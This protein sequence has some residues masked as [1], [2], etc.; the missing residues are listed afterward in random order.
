MCR[1]FILSFIA[2]LFGSVALAA[3]VDECYENDLPGCKDLFKNKHVNVYKL[4]E[5]AAIRASKSSKD[6]QLYVDLPKLQESTVQAIYPIMLVESLKFGFE[7]KHGAQYNPDTG[8]LTFCVNS[9]CGSK[10]SSERIP[11]PVPTPEPVRQD[12]AEEPPKP[13]QV[14]DNEAEVIEL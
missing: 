14:D 1:F 3:V 7:I 13:E 12:T 9:S 10:T 2:I 8:R 5:K 11:R 6:V 4:I